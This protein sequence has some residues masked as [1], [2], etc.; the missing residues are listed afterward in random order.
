MSKKIFNNWKDQWEYEANKSS[1]NY[2]NK[3]LKELL[4]K[5]EN[6]QVGIFYNIWDVIAQK[7]SPNDESLQI[8]WEYLRDH[9]GEKFELDRYHCAAALFK[10]LF[11][12]EN[13]DQKKLRVE[14]QWDHQGEEKRQKAL[15]KLHKLFPLQHNS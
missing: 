4:K 7:S 13:E 5:V 1:S 10:I 6:N 11:P 9:P 2:I 3:D 8:L 12:E 15:K 14:V